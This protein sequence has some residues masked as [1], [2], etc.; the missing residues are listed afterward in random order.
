M[1]FLLFVAGHIYISLSFSHDQ[2]AGRTKSKII[3]II[4]IV[5]DQKKA[6]VGSIRRSLSEF[7]VRIEDM[8]PH[9]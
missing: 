2:R 4:V 9:A 5:S 3:I 7:D 1:K 6:V 8:C